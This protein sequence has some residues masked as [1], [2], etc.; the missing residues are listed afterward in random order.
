MK[1]KCTLGPFLNVLVIKCLTHHFELTCYY[2]Y[3]LRVKEKEIE[4]LGRKLNI[5]Y[6][7]RN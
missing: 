1:G 6:N 2:E 7:W 5:L 4:S 3:E